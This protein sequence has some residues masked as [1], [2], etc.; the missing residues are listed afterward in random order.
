M[1]QEILIKEDED[2]SP[3]IRGKIKIIQ[4]REGYRFNI[5]SLLLVDFLN[6]KSSGKIIDIGTGSGIIPILISLKYKNLKL[7]A[8]EVQEDLFDIAKRN[9]QINN[10]HVQ[11]ALG[12]VKDV[13]KIYN[14]QY[15][16]YVVINPP[17]FKE[18]N[19]KNIQEKIAR[20]EALAKLEDFIYGSWYLLKNKGKL[21]LINITERFSETVSLLKKYNIQ[22]KRYRFVHPSI[23]E[24]ATHFLVEAS[25][26]SKEGGEIVEAP[27]II[28]ENPKEKK[29][30][31]YVWN[32]LE[33]GF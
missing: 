18:G 10:V 13:K 21:H 22:P 12:N 1:N 4:K 11:I 26:N 5:D 9:F 27:L 16:D 20:S 25:K 8:L 7:Y 28:Y 33:N 23:N 6:I 24:K 2:I 19:Y 17:Y 14:H 15:F 30:T 31:D 3:F 29:Y 32:L